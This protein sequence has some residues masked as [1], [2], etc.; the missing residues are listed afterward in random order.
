MPWIQA[1]Q[2]LIMA[3]F[4]SAELAAAPPAEPG[5]ELSPAGAA[6]MSG[7]G[8]GFG[9]EKLGELRPRPPGGGS[10][11]GGAAGPPMPWMAARNRD[12][13]LDEMLV[14]LLG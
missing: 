2:A 10:S 7:S 13:I 6:A 11:H 8:V 9:H 14:K 1:L 12:D 4:A 3:R 5:A